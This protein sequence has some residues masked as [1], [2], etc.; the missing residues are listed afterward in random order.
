MLLLLGMYLSQEGLKK[1]KEEL[2]RRKSLRA[3]IAQK[4][5][6]AKSL[7]DISENA[8]YQEALTAQSFNEGKIMELEEIVR[9]ADVVL[10]TASHR[11]ANVEIGAQVKTESKFGTRQFTIVGSSEADPVQGF[12]SDESPLGRAF[13][14]H[15]IGEE[16]EVDTPRGKAKYRI[17]EIL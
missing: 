2:E 9:E 16:V 13:M 1:L 6:E 12:I 3:E 4:I 11:H 17:L 10:E 7:G 8:E 15:K 14:G 5:Q